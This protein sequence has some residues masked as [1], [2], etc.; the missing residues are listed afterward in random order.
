MHRLYV[1]TELV[2]GA[3][4]RLQADRA[5]YL[6]TVLRCRPGQQLRVFDGRGGE[7]GATLAGCGRQDAVLEVG[8]YCDVQTRSALPI[9][10]AIAIARGE[11]MDWAVQKAVELGAASIQ[12]LISERCTVRLER[13]RAAQRHTHWWK[14]VIAACEQSG[15]VDLPELR[16]AEDLGS[17]LEPGRIGF[18]LDPAATRN[19]QQQPVPAGPVDLL[20]GPEGGLSD[21][22]QLRAAGAG[23]VPVRF[24]PRILR[25]ET[26]AAVG[27][28][29]LQLLWGDLR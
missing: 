24:G 8:A 15:R 25:N 22:E 9:T 20:V 5:H 18:V 7:Y 10:L 13:T 19:L 17:W 21:A 4:L 27:V 28:A 11:R 26:A 23:L 12:P 2:E 14:I 1:A 6:C 3:E 29:A 16:P